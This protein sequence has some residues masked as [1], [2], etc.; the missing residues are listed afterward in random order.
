MMLTARSRLRNSRRSSSG[1]L[2]LKEYRTK[3]ATR[4]RPISAGTSTL[5]V[6]TLPSAG[7]EETP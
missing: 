5:G 6:P 7:I 1:C 4:A 3:A 2:G